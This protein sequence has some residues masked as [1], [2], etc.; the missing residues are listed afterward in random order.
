VSPAAGG[1]LQERWVSRIQAGDEQAFEAVFSTYAGQLQEVARRIVRCREAATEIVQEVFYR[2]WRNRDNL[3]I[4]E[5]LAGYLYRATRNRALDH[6]KRRQLERQWQA[7]AWRARAAAT[8]D[9]S[10]AASADQGEVADA[11]VEALARLPE[12]R[13][14][15]LMLR[16]RDGLSYQEIAER[17]GIAVKTVENQVGRGLKEVRARL[18]RDPCPPGR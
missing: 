10:S 7:E 6:L 15:V 11:F 4:R 9:S 18:R 3:E 8:P 1:G 2:V 16:F 14:L 17:L 5:Q 12:R 13:R